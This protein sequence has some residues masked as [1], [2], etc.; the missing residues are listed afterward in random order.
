MV[1]AEFSSSLIM[2]EPGVWAA[3]F[4]VG[5]ATARPYVTKTVAL[6]AA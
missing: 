2:D 5:A 4:G 1:S 6:L 3:E